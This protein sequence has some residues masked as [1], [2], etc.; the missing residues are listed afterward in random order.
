MKLRHSFHYL[1]REQIKLVWQFSAILGW[2]SIFTILSIYDDTPVLA[3]GSRDLVA[4]GGSRPYTEWRTDTTA[5]ILRRTVLKVYA[6]GN[7]VINLGSS[8]VGVGS[9]N[10]RLFR[11]NANVDTG[12]AL[13][14]CN[15]ER[16]KPDVSSA[17]GV[18]N[19]RNQEIAGPSPATGGYTPCVYPVQTAGIYQVVFYG[20]DGISGARD[21]AT[22]A[23]GSI[24][25]PAIGAEQNS[26]V[27]MWDITVRNSNAPTIDLTGRVFTD[28]IAL[29]MNDS[30]R[31]LKSKLYIL[32]TDGY[33]YLTDFGIGRGIDPFGF[34]FF[35]NKTGLLDV[36][37]KI[38]YRSGI[39]T[40][41]SNSLTD[42]GKVPLPT[43]PS[44]PTYPTFFN[45]PSMAAISGLAYP[46]TAQAPAAPTNFKF[47]GGTGGGLNQ[48]PQ[49]VG[50]TFSFDAPQ[51][52]SYQII[53]DTDGNGIYAPASGDL[54]LTGDAVA[55]TNNIIWNGKNSSGTVNLL[56][57]S[58]NR[59]YGSKVI[60][61]G[62]EY[63]FPLLDVENVPDGF[64]IEMLN[65]PT[66]FSN[67][68]NATTIY[69]DE[70]NYT[71]N[72]TAFNLGC[73]ST[74][75]DGR[76]GVDSA[77]GAHNFA[78]KYGDQKAIDSWIYFPSSEVTNS[79]VIFNTK[80]SGKVWDDANN[81]ANDTFTSL[82]TTNKVGT[83]AGGLN[84][85]LIGSS[86]NV[87]STA[88][89]AAD[90]TY[91]FTDVIPNQN[92]LKVKIG[93]GTSPLILPTNWVKTTPL[94]TAAFN[95][96]TTNI[97]DVNFGVEQLPVAVGTDT[98]NKVNP[99]GM[100]S[101]AIPSTVFTSSIDADGTII[102]YKIT[103]VPT[104]ATSITI[105]GTKYTTANFPTSGVTVT[106]AKL[107]TIQVDPIDG[108]VTVKISFQAIDNA[109][110]TSGNI[111]T[112]DIPFVLPVSNMQLIKR[113]TAIDG[114]PTKLDG[115][116]LNTYEAH[117]NPS[118]K[119]LDINN[120][121]LGATNGGTIK[122]WSSIEYTIY[123]L[124]NGDIPANNVL[125]CD[126]VPNNV[127][128]IPQAYNTTT[129]APNG[130]STADRGIVINRGGELLAYTNTIDGDIAQY[131]PPNIQP[132]DV[133]PSIKCGG[134]NTNGAVVIN[135]GTLPHAT[136][137]GLPPSSYGFFRFQGLVK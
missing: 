94:T 71:I 66:A 3:E 123:F 73:N 114:L 137:A 81:S 1:L 52:G 39:I 63:H 32:T 91:I 4:N 82:N 61:K 36:N 28:Y 21:P 115:T 44:Y 90:G 23:N 99:G 95:I 89:V 49:G 131:F 11:G 101:I 43:D 120:F 27:S 72:T 125:L 77:L 64:K 38:L 106:V 85:F 51:A 128:F 30:G 24:D 117:P 16:A 87:L 6:N 112:T 108:K 9:G 12:T 20:P 19:T 70:R 54:L 83:N 34:I 116:A 96:T 97:N 135:L 136:T 7:E 126:R 22:A 102:A 46:A 29:N 78:S 13:L 41:T 134:A 104:N 40:T 58:N 76:T 50:G 84:A 127:T 124:S 110:K 47:T 62:G 103:A 122:P 59:A 45:R 2:I 98:A 8:A 65:P 109:G 113:I 69:F 105:D 129:A 5:G 68:K 14:D 60:L 118:N 42:G 79:F 75:C 15:V 111:A 31:Y 37:N 33:Q 67:G 88:P 56:P 130:S 35:A 86:G 92:N 53:I 57:L 25:P 119:W 80:I 132:T 93:T 121:L 107:T 10:I 100:N 48:S 26:A 133:F 74:I 55:G 18:L 17:T